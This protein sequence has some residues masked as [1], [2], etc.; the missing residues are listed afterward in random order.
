MLVIL[1]S[2]FLIILYDNSTLTED[3]YHI[4]YSQEG[5]EIINNQNTSYPYDSENINIIQELDESNNYHTFNFYLEDTQEVLD[6][7]VYLNNVHLGSTENGKLYVDSNQIE[8]G[9]L[10]IEGSSSEGIFKEIFEI[11]EEDSEYEIIDFW[12]SSNL[13][14]YNRI[15]TNNSKCIFSGDIYDVDTNYMIG[16]SDETGVYFYDLTE[17]LPSSLFLD[18]NMVCEDGEII[19]DSWIVVRESKHKINEDSIII[20]IN[21]HKPETYYEFMNYIRPDD[22]RWWLEKYINKKV[23]GDKEED[24]KIIWSYLD[25]KFNYLYDDK[26]V[27]ELE[28][29][30]LPNETLI[31]NRGDCED[32]SVAFVSLTKAYDPSIKCYSMSLIS[33]ES[34]ICKY[35]EEE[36]EHYIII[37]MSLYMTEIVSDASIKQKEIKKRQL[38][39]FFN[40]YFNDAGLIEENRQIDAI[41][42]GSDIVFFEDFDEFLIYL[43]EI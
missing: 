30:Q 29:W 41:F 22:V 38:E 18:G 14:D 40:D 39:L 1:L 37:D 21:I 26:G 13:P 9:E 7:D 10:M 34:S 20:E 28:Y 19:P 4:P 11:N 31:K 43:I 2:I 35:T 36:D 33:H 25:G 24:I 12:I 8:A 17:G 23:L 15:E 32:F 5:Q 42:D 3:L 27:N 6:G 16:L